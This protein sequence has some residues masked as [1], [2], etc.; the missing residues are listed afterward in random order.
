MSNGSGTDRRFSRDERGRELFTA[1]WGRTYLVQ[2]AETG[3]RLRRIVRRSPWLL[4]LG[5]SAVVTPL[6]LLRRP[7]YW[8]FLAT[9]LLLAID[10]IPI[11]RATR[12]LERV[13]WRGPIPSVR[14][15]HREQARSISAT[16]L[17]CLEA[18]ALAGLV[19]AAPS[20]VRGGETSL[21]WTTGGLSAAAA[22]GFAWLLWLR[23]RG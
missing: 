20:L 10:L 2:D 6:V 4:A 12:G 13:R 5:V 9:P 17:W 11:H 7:W 16:R 8:V 1:P 15:I 14:E 18:I 21:G 19:F 23:S 22:I 3:S